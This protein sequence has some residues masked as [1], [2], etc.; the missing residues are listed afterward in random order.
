MGLAAARLRA[1]AGRIDPHLRLGRL[2]LLSEIYWQRRS[3][4][5]MFG[6]LLGAVM[7]IVLLFSMAGI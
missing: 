7:L 2:C 6:D 5:H 3:V 4:D 1:V